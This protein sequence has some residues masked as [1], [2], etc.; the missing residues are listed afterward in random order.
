MGKFILT[1]FAVTLY[2]CVMGGKDKKGQRTKGNARPS[3]SGRSAELLGTTTGF[4][5][6]SGVPEGSYVPA[7]NVASHFP[8]DDAELGISA[9]FRMTLRKM[10]KKDATTKIKALQEFTE[11]CEQSPID[12]LK[13]V[14]TFW[15]RLFTR[16]SVDSD[17]RVPM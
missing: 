11:Y 8:N 7:V 15:P 2:I 1:S 12:V 3:S 16:L 13:S 17:R 5:G 9:D 10:G 14:L 4:I 6:F